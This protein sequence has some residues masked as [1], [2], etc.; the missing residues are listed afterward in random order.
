MGKELGIS[1]AR[2]ASDEYRQK[3]PTV[4]RE[5]CPTGSPTETRKQKPR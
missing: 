1:N 4:A 2:C 3:H 5:R